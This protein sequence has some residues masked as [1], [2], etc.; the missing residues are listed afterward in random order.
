MTKKITVDYYHNNG[1]EV[2]HSYDSTWEETDLHCLQ[3]GKPS[4][5]AENGG[6]YYQGETHICLDCGYYFNLPGYPS[7]GNEDAQK[8]QVLKFLKEI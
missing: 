4:L 5:W 2:S 1:T 8:K 6:D 7:D 3:C